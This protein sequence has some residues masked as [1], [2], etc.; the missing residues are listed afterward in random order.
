M[1]STTVCR[2]MQALFRKRG[3]LFL[4]QALVFANQSGLYPLQ[5][6][7]VACAGWD[8]CMNIGVVFPKWRGLCD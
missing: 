3:A 5:A 8:G 7:C 1:N 6:A 2:R 4:R